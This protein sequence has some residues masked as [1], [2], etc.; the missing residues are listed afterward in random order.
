VHHTHTHDFGVRIERVGNISY[1]LQST[2]VADGPERFF[3]CPTYSD[4]TI[5]CQA[6]DFYAHR[7]VLASQSRH[8]NNMLDV[9]DLNSFGYKY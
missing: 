8:F 6:R 5:R 9:R 1:S 7:L 3:N 4:L 2:A